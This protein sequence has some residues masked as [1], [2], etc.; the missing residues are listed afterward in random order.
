MD[1]VWLYGLQFSRIGGAALGCPFWLHLAEKLFS[2]FWCVKSSDVGLCD[3]TL[4]A[5]YLAEHLPAIHYFEDL[6]RSRATFMSTEFNLM[7]SYRAKD[8]C[9]DAAG[10]REVQKARLVHFANHWLNFQ[11]L[12]EN[13]EAAGRVD[14][15]RCY[16]GAFHYWHDLYHHA[17]QLIESKSQAADPP[18]Y[19][20]PPRDLASGLATPEEVKEIFL[21]FQEIKENFSG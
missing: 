21:N 3:Q 10:Q 6:P 18:L 20:Q 13:R 9:E 5:G 12:I 14:S 19:H 2:L 1:V 15:P 11:A 17:M 16:K 7:V 4:V 8:R